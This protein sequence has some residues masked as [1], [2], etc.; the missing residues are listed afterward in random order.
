MRA[1]LLAGIGALI[2]SVRPWRRRLPLDRRRRPGPSFGQRAAEVQGPGAADRYAAVRA[3]P[4][5]AARG[6]GPPGAR[7]PGDRRLGADGARLAGP[8][9]P[10]SA[11][12]APEADCETLHRRYRESLDCFAPFVTGNGTLKPNA[13]AACKPVVDPSPKCGPPKAN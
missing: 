1:I 4:R 8:T 11:A 9:G 3:D 2:A 6:R 7:A 13:F 5:A 12:S 10:A